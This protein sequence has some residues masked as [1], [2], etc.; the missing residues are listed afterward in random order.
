M[1]L[2]ETTDG[3]SAIEDREP[4]GRRRKIATESQ[5]VTE[6]AGMKILQAV[7]TAAALST[8]LIAN[9][10]MLEGDNVIFTFDESTLFGSTAVVSG[11][12]LSILPTDFVAQSANGNGGDN[13]VIVSQTINVLVTAKAGQQLTDASL[14]EQGDY[15]LLDLGGGVPAV[16]ASGEFNVTAN[17]STDQNAFSAGALTDITSFAS[18]GTSGWSAS[19]SADSFMADSAVLQVQN[20]LAAFSVNGGDAAFIEKK[21]VQLTVVTTPV[22]LPASF[23]LLL[24]GVGLAFAH[25]RKKAA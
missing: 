18:F 8:S 5:A 10:A 21:L 1:N 25:G 4:T 11:D 19:V 17:G 12:T 24:S 23:W 3:S 15:F 13:V 7:F 14:F 16:G 22:P 2:F 20:I 9:A 6:N